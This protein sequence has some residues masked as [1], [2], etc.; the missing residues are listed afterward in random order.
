[1]LTNV[2]T[3]LNDALLA[4]GVVECTINGR[5]IKRDYAQLLDIEKKLMQRQS[6]SSSTGPLRSYVNFGGRPS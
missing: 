3:A 4:G 5:T 6:S 2:R 1:M